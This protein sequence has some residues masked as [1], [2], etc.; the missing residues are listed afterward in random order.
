MENQCMER[1][2]VPE[3]IQQNMMQ[4]V[5][6]GVPSLFE[7]GIEIQHCVLDD[8]IALGRQSQY[9]IDKGFAGI[10]TREEFMKKVP[11]SDYSDYV[12]YINDN[13][14]N[15]C[16][17]VVNLPTE[18]YLLS[19]GGAAFKG[20]YYIET[21]I[22]ALAR[23]L[24]IDLWNLHLAKL[25]PKMT[26]SDVKMMAITNCAPI[27]NAPNGKVVR[28][29]SSQ[30][31]KGLWEKN[32]ELYVFP[33]EF[34]EAE[35]T[36]DDRD[37]MIALYALKERNLNMLFCNNLGYFG[38]LLD[39][40]ERYPQRMIQD[41]RKG[42]FSVALDDE[43][44]AILESL[45]EADPTRADELQRFIEED[46]TFIVEKV[47]PCFEFSGVWLTGTVGEFSRDVQKRLPK[48]MRYL[49]E[50]YG[51]SEVMINIP[52]E[53][54]LKY[55]PLAVY[56]CFFEFMPLGETDIEKL[57]TIEEIKDGEY[58]EIIVS[59]YSG[60]YRYNLG[61]IVCVRGFTG[62]TPNIE[63]CCRRSEDINLSAQKLY[64]HEFINLIMQI[65]K[66][67]GEQFAFYQALVEN[68]QLSLVIQLMNEDSEWL[69][70]CRKAR[71]ITKQK[72]ISLNNI[73]F[74]SKAYRADLYEQLKKNGRTV[75]CIKLPMIAMQR[76]KE[77]FLNA[78]YEVQ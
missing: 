14:Q 62:N 12:T 20:K 54:N 71:L 34:L 27:E 11:L 16:G 57:L 65:E 33:Y 58:Y 45:F 26:E 22:G 50:S 78:V 72:G 19:T 67:S 30:A 49:S 40:I 2:F 46:G 73:F 35:M 56:S 3:F 43:D 76:P 10:T 24:S 25:E 28:R 53:Y 74:V 41:I 9:A 70:V 37:Y 44:S 4:Y 36:D 23:Q 52:L 7:H 1:Q 31:A 77:H 8:I 39:N 66:E 48:N 5:Q 63:F 64:G 69:N 59:T 55:G 13:M 38:D 61:D 42:R 60:L 75:Q 32:P 21:K 18:Y 68:D 6:K 47:W 17:Q 51:T 15:D 29:T